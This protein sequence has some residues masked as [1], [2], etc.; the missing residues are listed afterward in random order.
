MPSSPRPDE[1]VARVVEPDPP[2]VVGETPELPLPLGT[3]AD[4]VTSARPS[5][6]GQPAQVARSRG[7]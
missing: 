2:E 7:N 6:S 5:G 3:E 4:A 1:V